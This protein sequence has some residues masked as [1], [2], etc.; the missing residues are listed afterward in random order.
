MVCATG[1]LFFTASLRAASSIHSNLRLL[2]M[3]YGLPQ[4]ADLFLSPCLQQHLNNLIE[5]LGP[6]S[7]RL[8]ASYRQWSR[9]ITFWR[10][11]V[12]AFEK[13]K[14][15]YCCIAAIAGSE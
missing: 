8:D 15:H 5:F 6:I 14:F 9:S 3:Y 2:L 11:W 1:G 12:R 13:Q 4:R 10:N 7:Q